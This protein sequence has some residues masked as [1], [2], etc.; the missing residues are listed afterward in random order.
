VPISAVCICAAAPGRIKPALKPVLD[1]MEQISAQIE[2]LNEG[3]E[4]TEE[5]F[6]ETQDVVEVPPGSTHGRCTL[7][8]KARFNKDV[9]SAAT[10]NSVLGATQSGKP[11]STA[12]NHR[13][14]G[15][16]ARKKVLHL[17]EGKVTAIL[18]VFGRAARI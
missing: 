8:E 2:I 5:T 18:D 17:E 7:V 6:P 3:I 16:D 10:S 13:T 4:M 15:Q 12:K 11:Y 14:G 1:Q 9:G